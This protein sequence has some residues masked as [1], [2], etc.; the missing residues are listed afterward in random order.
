M[1]KI[2][3]N[4]SHDYRD[5]P[6]NENQLSGILIA[7]KNEIVND[8]E[9]SKWLVWSQEH[10]MWWRDN[11]LGYTTSRRLAGR[12][13]FQEAKEIVASANEHLAMLPNEAMVEDVPVLPMA[14]E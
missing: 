7:F 1:D 3:Q 4:Y 5:M 12:Y 9:K 10:K 14:K 2:I 11:H 8:L 13:S 6:M